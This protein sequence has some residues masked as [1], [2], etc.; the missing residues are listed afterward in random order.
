MAAAISRRLIRSLRG[1]KRIRKSAATWSKAQRKL[2]LQLLEGRLDLRSN[3]DSTRRREG[4]KI[5]CRPF[6]P[7]I[8]ILDP[9]DSITSCAVH[10]KKMTRTRRAR[11]ETTTPMLTERMTTAW[12]GIRSEIDQLGMVKTSS[13][14]SPSRAPCTRVAIHERPARDSGLSCRQAA[15]RRPSLARWGNLGRPFPSRTLRSRFLSPQK[16]P[17]KLRS[18]SSCG[19]PVSQ[20]RCRGE[21]R[22]PFR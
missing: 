11:A 21:E 22:G 20:L 4:G 17:D 8:E 10:K 14:G 6:L 1:L 13:A 16:C 3:T 12:S 19:D 18:K 15:P 2:W 7:D 5:E 9:I